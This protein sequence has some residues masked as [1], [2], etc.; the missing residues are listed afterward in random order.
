M[1]TIY[2]GSI[3]AVK[4]T[5]GNFLACHEVNGLM[6]GPYNLDSWVKGLLPYKFEASRLYKCGASC[7]MNFGRVV[8]G[9]V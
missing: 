8:L 5:G 3:S 2:A 4:L 1:A 6:E 9:R 7:L